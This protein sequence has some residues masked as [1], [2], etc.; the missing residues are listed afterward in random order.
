MIANILI[1]DDDENIRNMLRTVLEEAHHR[2]LEA[3][4]GAQAFTM[5]EEHRPHLIIM[6]VVMPG[7]YGTTAAKKLHEYR[8]TADI[9]IIIFSGTA[10]ESLLEEVGLKDDKV[11]FLHKP[12]DAKTILETIRKMLPEGGYTQ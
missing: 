8:S 6:D 5:A 1:V 3:T 2:V 11:V 9:P 12:S 7:L 4:D 10:D